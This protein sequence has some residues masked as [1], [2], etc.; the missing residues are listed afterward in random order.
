LKFLIPFITFATW[1]PNRH[2]PKVIITVATSI[3]VGTWIE[4]YTWLS[5]SVDPE[6]YHMP[7]TSIFDIVVTVIVFGAAFGIVKWTLNRYGLIKA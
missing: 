4:R 3:V 7:M 2:N 5:G 6:H 1:T